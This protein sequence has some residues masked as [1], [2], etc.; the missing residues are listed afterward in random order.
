VT[1][2]IVFGIIF[3]IGFYLFSC[4]VGFKICEKF[5]IGSLFE[6]CIPIYNVVLLCRCADISGWNALWYIIPAAF[7]KGELQVLGALI[8]AVFTVVLFGRIAERM[9]RS[10]WQYGLGSAF[11]LGI[12]V[13]VLAFGPARP[14]VQSA[15]QG[16]DRERDD[17]AAPNTIYKP[18]PIKNSTLPARSSPI[19][20]EQSTV[21]IHCYMGELKG[22]TIPVPAQGIIIGRDPAQCQLVLSSKELSRIHTAIMVEKDNPRN[23]IIR[24]LQ[25]TNGTFHQVQ[26]SLNKARW[27]RING[28]V[29]LG[30]G[31]R[32]RIGKDV[33]EFEVC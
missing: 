8:S 15:V 6:C 14:R 4:F 30:P 3:G 18:L 17:S 29:V 9:G 13:L 12:P 1:E 2:A 33:A 24:D 27:K 28:S 23:I 7:F 26:D 16:G 5:G 25:S 31:E 22:N 20:L 19:A 21:S 10:F 11:L 32:F